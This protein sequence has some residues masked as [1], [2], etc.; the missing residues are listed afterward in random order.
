M[1]LAIMRSRMVLVALVLAAVASGCG[2]VSN[3]ADDHPKP[4]GGVVKDL[5]FVVTPCKDSAFTGETGGKGESSSW[6]SGPP[7]WA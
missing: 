7:T 6:V 5:E 4:Y 2:T 3:F 1:P